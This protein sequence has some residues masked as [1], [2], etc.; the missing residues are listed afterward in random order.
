M[1]RG[2]GLSGEIVITV[3]GEE[4]PYLRI[5]SDGKVTWL[6]SDEDQKRYEQAMMKNAGENMSRFYTAHPE[7]LERIS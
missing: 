5:D 4:V 3:N 2:R 1:R 6:V 7:Y